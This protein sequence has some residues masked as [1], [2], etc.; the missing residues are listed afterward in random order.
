MNIE[1]TKAA[2]AVMQA[3]VDGKDIE[4]R[5]LDDTASK[6]H[7]MTNLIWNWYEKDYR[8]K[9]EPKIIYVNEYEYKDKSVG[10]TVYTKESTAKLRADQD[11]KDAKAVAVPYIRLTD[12]EL[13]K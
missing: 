8:I 2:I 13:L 12:V 11:A 7:R 4:T 9:P 6:W 10:Y 1:D 3:Y 5:V